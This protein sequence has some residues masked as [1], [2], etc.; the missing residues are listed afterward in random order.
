MPNPNMAINAFIT[1]KLPKSIV[2]EQH[3]SAVDLANAAVHLLV[4]DVGTAE[5]R[6]LLNKRLEDYQ[7]DY[8]GYRVVEHKAVQHSDQMVCSCGASWD[9]N[10]PCPP[11]GH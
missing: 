10:D 8:L 2:R 1:I 4:Q 7:Q 6:K 5:A 11:E 3:R 9:V